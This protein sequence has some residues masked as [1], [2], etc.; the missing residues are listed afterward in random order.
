MVDPFHQRPASVHYD[1]E[2]QQAQR[3]NVRQYEFECSQQGSVML[4][5]CLKVFVWLV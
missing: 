3:D 4:L 1:P 2:D 5:C